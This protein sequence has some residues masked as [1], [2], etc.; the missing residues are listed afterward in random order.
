[1]FGNYFLF[2]I[3]KILIK[4]FIFYMKLTF[5]KLIFNFFM[6]YLLYM[7]FY[8]CFEKNGNVDKK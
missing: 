4:K 8:L 6:L 3:L 5:L 7:Y 1:M 2:F